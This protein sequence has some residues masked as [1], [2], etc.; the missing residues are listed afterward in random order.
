LSIWR[1]AGFDVK[2]CTTATQIRVLWQTIVHTV[3]IP[4]AIGIAW[5]DKMQ[6]AVHKARLT[7]H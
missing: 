5:T 3:F 4:S 7:D 6:V 2:T 1:A